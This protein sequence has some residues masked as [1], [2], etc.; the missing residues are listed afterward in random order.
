MPYYEPTWRASR[1]R[2]DDLASAA[3]FA[4]NLRLT[5]TV[6]SGRGESLDLGPAEETFKSAM[7]SDLDTPVAISVVVKLADEILKAAD[8]GRDVVQA[9]QTLRSWCSLFGLRLDKDRP[10][11][12]VVT[13]W[14]EHRRRFGAYG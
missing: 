13:G 3:E 1:T 10:E 12:N 8:E 7:D 11:E 4:R 14:T 5:V 2:E 6:E 9:Q